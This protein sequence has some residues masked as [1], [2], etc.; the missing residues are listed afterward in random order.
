[1]PQGRW[2]VTAPHPEWSLCGSA[3]PEDAFVYYARDP[4]YSNCDLIWMCT[5]YTFMPPTTIKLLKFKK[6]FDTI[7]RKRLYV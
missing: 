3:Q 6:P 4:S 1:M 5:S 7:P 2:F